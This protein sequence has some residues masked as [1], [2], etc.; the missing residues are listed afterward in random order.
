MTA[1]RAPVR[2]GLVGC[3][4]VAQERHL[5]ALKSLSSAKVVAVADVNA[6]R[7]EMVAKRFQV[8]RR[9]TDKL[10]SRIEIQ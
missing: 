4:R 1:S 7:L 8:G 5:P 6:N 9:A 10:H 3:G 2:I